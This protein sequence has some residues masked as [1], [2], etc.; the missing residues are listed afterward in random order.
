MDDLVGGWA[1]DDHG[2]LREIAALAVVIAL[3]MAVAGAVV[4]S[5]IVGFR[6]T[7][8]FLSEFVR[9]RPDPRRGDRRPGAPEPAYNCM[10]SGSCAGRAQQ[11]RG[12][13]DAMQDGRRRTAAFAAG[14]D[15][16][17]MP[18]GIGAL[19]GGVVGT[20][21]GAVITFVVTL[22]ILLVAR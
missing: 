12:A 10:R 21:V 18:L 4:G 16:A 9:A 6:G 7:G 1:S 11:Q 15:G 22:P 19:I 17:W 13:W 3:A 20:G 5:V 8:V 2:R 14:Q